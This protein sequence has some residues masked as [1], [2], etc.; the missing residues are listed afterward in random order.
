MLEKILRRSEYASEVGFT[1]IELMIVVAIIGILAAI[2]IPNYQ[3]NAIRARQTE[4]KSI[5]N[6]IHTNQVLYQSQYGTYGSTEAQLGMK[7][8][9]TPMYAIVFTGVTDKAYTATV[10]ANL[11]NDPSVDTWVLTEVSPVPTHTCDDVTNTG[12]AC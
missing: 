10:S 2:A 3:N 1:L 7:L 5:L 4:A 9:G 6:A 12:L 11:D 8:S